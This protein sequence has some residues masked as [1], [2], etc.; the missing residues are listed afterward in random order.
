MFEYFCI[1]HTRETTMF[2][3]RENINNYKRHR[4]SSRKMTTNRLIENN[5]SDNQIVLRYSWRVGHSG[6]GTEHP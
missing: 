2:D 3:E 5:V 4:Y 6:K 1:E